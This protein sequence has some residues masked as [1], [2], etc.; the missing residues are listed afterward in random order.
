MLIQNFLESAASQSPDREAL[1]HRQE[2]MSYAQ[3]EARSN[4]LARALREAGVKAG[5]RVAL[6]FDNSFR[7]VI[8]HFAILKAG[9]VNVS[10]NTETS[11]QT[12]AYLL[13]D[14]EAIAIFTAGK[15]LPWLAQIESRIPGLE[16]VFTEREALASFPG[17]TRIH[18]TE[19]EALESQGEGSPLLCET[20]DTDLASL[21]YT[22]G[23]TA[24]PKGVML[25]HR[26]LASNALS[27]VQYMGLTP[28]DRTLCVL[29]FHYI[30]GT[31][32]LYTHFAA[33]GSL[34]IENRFAYPN[35][36]L[37]TLEKTESTGFAGVPSTFA[38]LLAKSTLKK[39]TFPWLRYVAQAGGAMAPSLQK[40]VA[41]AFKPARLFIM[42]GC[43]EAAPRLTYLPPEILPAKWGSIGRAIPGVEVAVMDESGN[44]VVPGTVGEIAARGSNIMMGYWKDPKATGEAIRNGWY[45]TGDLGKED[46]DGCLF[47]VG[48]N[49]DFIKAGGNR[50][51]AQEIEEVLMEFGAVSEAAVIG[52]P[53]PIL[54]EAIK[55]FVVPKDGVS[56]DLGTL[57]AHL[58]ARL[59]LFKQPKFIEVRE[60]L[61]K[62]SAG[63]VLKA[64]LREEGEETGKEAG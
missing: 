46:E 5:D 49:K 35:V 20:Q 31:S 4:C 19:I 9:A 42:Y 55:A 53:D 23:S 29:P 18:A 58:N 32:L 7:Y 21:T 50:V 26:N 43:T 47:V 11:P 60:A 6:L 40:E 3:L 15:Y 30:Y 59:P 24:K 14:C 39:R 62:S 10:L 41:E 57:K 2:W 12:L 54:G 27:V 22:S 33:G 52:V 13:Q 56:L 38:I 8:A 16:H 25:S 61:P 17:F 28:E 37:D 48:R 45:Y 36:A 63:K 64:A 34:V 44:R 1:W 51:G